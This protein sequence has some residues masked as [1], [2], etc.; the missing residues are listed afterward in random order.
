MQSCVLITADRKLHG[1][2]VIAL[3]GFL[4]R[5]D[6]TVIITG[7]TSG[8]GLAAAK[9]LAGRGAFVIGVG[10][11][12][13]KCAQAEK[14]IRA[15]SPG[16]QIIFLLADLSSQ[17]QV[18]NLAV[19]ARRL[20]EEHRQGRLDVL[21]NNAGAVASKYSETEDG[22]E[23]Q[24]AVNHLAPFLL[25]HEL[26]PL[27]QAADSGRVLTV[28]SMSHYHIR[29]HWS[30]LMYR[31]GYNTLIVYKQSKLANVLFTA[32]FNRRINHDSPLRAYAIDP[33]LVNTEIGLKRTDGLS[34]WFW[35]WRRSK[36][37]SPEKGAETIVYLA[38]EAELKTPQE[39][40]WKAKQPKPASLAAHNQDDARRLWQLSE[41]M[42][43]IDQEEIY[44]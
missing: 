25:T 4:T 11:S 29:M 13:T 32:E 36:G 41:R 17:R 34:R 16:A 18:R 1:M 43:G 12:Q 8:I 21:V 31:N 23:F 10:R 15:A 6:K 30:D 37:D 9:A 28:S 19:Q 42:C 20:I 27:L 40:Y 33:G 35:N 44:P 2:K 3:N 14:D 22:I 26:L 24:F 38:C 39:I 5:I 7:A